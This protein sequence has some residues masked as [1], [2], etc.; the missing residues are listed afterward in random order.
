MKRKLFFVTPNTQAILSMQESLKGSRLNLVAILPKIELVSLK[1]REMLKYN[2]VIQFRD[3]FETMRTDDVL[4][5][6][7]RVT[8][9]NDHDWA[10]FLQRDYVVFF[11]KIIKNS[12]CT[13]AILAFRYDEGAA[14]ACAVHLSESLEGI[15]KERLNNFRFAIYRE[16]S[17]LVTALKEYL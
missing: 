12:P 13:N 3:N 1:E 15:E 10:V 17:D 5:L 7:L 8:N 14:A 4:M 2:R 6:D 16:S 9:Q 11:N